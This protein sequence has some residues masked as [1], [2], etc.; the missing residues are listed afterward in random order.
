MFLPFFTYF[1]TR[2]FYKLP[3]L[4]LI[5]KP[6]IHLVY[7]LKY[8]SA[9]SFAVLLLFFSLSVQAQIIEAKDGI[10]DL[11]KFPIEKQIAVLD[12]D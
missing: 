6:S 7:H 4:Y 10:L 11:R 2:L 3:T 9:F 5:F 12:G 8:I 1:Y